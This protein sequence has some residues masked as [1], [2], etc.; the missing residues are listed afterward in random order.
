[1]LSLVM[2]VFF[3]PLREHKHDATIPD[4]KLREI[5]ALVPLCVV[6]VW[7][8]VQPAFFLDRM[9]PSIDKVTAHAMTAVDTAQPPLAPEKDQEPW[10]VSQQRRAPAPVHA[11]KQE[12]VEIARVP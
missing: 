9:A 10:P 4:L 2:R 3:G 8:G 5:A 1:M 12:K 11:T 7:I 6:I